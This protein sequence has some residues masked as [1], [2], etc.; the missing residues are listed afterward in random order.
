MRGRRFRATAVAF[1]AVLVAAPAAIAS[2]GG[3]GGGGGTPAPCTPLTTVVSLGH[4]DGNGQSSIG[5][6]AT[7][8]DCTA[9]DQQQLHLNVAVPGSATKPFDADL[10]LHPG[11]SLTRNASPIGS[12]PLLLQY[13][14]TY[15]VV[16]TLTNTATTPAS[17]ISTVT[18]TVTMPPG[19][20]R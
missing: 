14:H 17:V 18:A 10:A 13:G 7:V 11:G 12:T 6:L 9:S 15:H 3:G 20:V 16:A 2:G 4:A 1:S 19:V 8:R 5:V